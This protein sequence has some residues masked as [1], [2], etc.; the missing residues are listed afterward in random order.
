MCQQPAKSVSY[1]ARTRLTSAAGLFP[2]QDVA[3]C[4]FL[5]TWARL[6]IC[7]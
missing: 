7:T 5:E 3:T 2:G 6:A 4:R 1:F